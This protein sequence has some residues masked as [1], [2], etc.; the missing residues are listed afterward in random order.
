MRLGIFAGIITFA[1]V[2]LS[3]PAEA[4]RFTPL[5]WQQQVIDH[6]NPVL[7]GQR[8]HTTWNRDQ[9]RNFIDDA[10]EKRF[11]SGDQVNILVN[12]N[13]CLEG[14][15]VR[16]AF[17]SFGR[18][19]YVGRMMG[20]IALIYV[21]FD[22]LP[23]IAAL[24]QVAMVEWQEPFYSSLDASTRS[25]Q[26]KESNAF[27]PETAGDVGLL[28]NGVTI[29]IVDTGVDNQNHPT[30][31]GKFVAG[32]DAV[33]YFDS[34]PNGIDDNCESDPNDVFCAPRDGSDDPDPNHPGHPFLV[35]DNHGTAVAGVA[36]GAGSPGDCGP[37]LDQDF[38][39]KTCE[40]TAPAARLVDVIA[41]FRNSVGVRTC[42]NDFT[43]A[44]LDWLAEKRATFDI[45]VINLSLGGCEPDDGTS[46]GAQMANYLSSLGVS[47]VFSHGNASTCDV[48][49]G[50]RLTGSPGSASFA[51]TVAGIDDRN[52]VPRDDDLRFSSGLTGPRIDFEA[53]GQ[54]D[55]LKP[56]IAGPADGV[57]TADISPA[58]SYQSISGTSFAAPHVA[59]AVALVLE[60]QP[61]M[62]PGSVKNLLMVTADTQHNEAAFPEVDSVWDEALGAGSL[63]IFAALDATASGDVGFPN[64]AGPSGAPGNPCAL[65]DGNPFW[66]NSDDIILLGPPQ[67]GEENLIGATIRNDGSATATFQVTFGVKEFGAGAEVFYHV[68]TQVVTLSPGSQQQITQ[69]WT[70]ADADH[71]CIQVEI[72]YGLDTNFS[73][74]VTQRNIWLAPSVYEMQV[75]NPFM[76]LADFEVE[77]TSD[78]DDWLCTISE[79]EFQLQPFYRRPKQLTIEFHAPEDARPGD[80]ADC[81]VAV[82]GK[83]EGTEQ[84]QLIGGVTVQTFVPE[85]CRVIGV[86]RGADDSPIANAK[87][88]F[89]PMAPPGHARPA[90]AQSD[91]DGVFSLHLT[92][93]LQ[94]RLTIEGEGYGSA[95]IELKPNCG[96]GD[97][98]LRLADGEIDIADQ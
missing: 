95:E 92:P 81:D 4:C 37:V 41:C 51:I 83:P 87:I 64:C 18:I 70:P 76:T 72:N 57:V 36:L 82:F 73:N 98:R 39:L 11:K 23:E 8:K 80:R 56:D 77:L 22:R 85:P 93:L 5:A 59:G 79:Q 21:D 10:I 65:A 42:V 32:F 13:Q 89:E 7:K 46:A 67:E 74:N 48:V 40:G 47:V 30:F 96:I 20:I 9:N 44:A 29:A 14:A 3:Q 24:P 69:L 15:E 54:I 49:G 68:G 94:H 33:D 78:E 97:L 31:A 45:D 61:D 60:Q 12:L 84:L 6:V 58:G 71:Q 88:A 63:N 26:S 55:A 90:S 43:I 16:N 38:T 1:F 62:P 27:S 50:T 35:P 52:T 19:R 86:L 2:I 25:I 34:Q 17:E 53:T 91:A 75:E 28:G 66:N